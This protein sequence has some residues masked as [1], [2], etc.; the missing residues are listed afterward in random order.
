MITHCVHACLQIRNVRQV[1]Y[2]LHSLIQELE[3]AKSEVVIE[4]LQADIAN[5]KAKST[6]LVLALQVNY[7]FF[8][9][10]FL[11]L[12]NTVLGSN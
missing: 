10:P 2:E 3:S 1:Q 12:Y 5:L 11:L 4:R 8:H 7:F 9:V 6:K